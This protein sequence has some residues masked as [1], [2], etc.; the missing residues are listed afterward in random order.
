MNSMQ[1]LLHKPII[2]AGVFGDFGRVEY[3]KHKQ[4]Q[5]SRSRTASINVGYLSFTMWSREYLGLL[6][7]RRSTVPSFLFAWAFFNFLTKTLSKNRPKWFHKSLTNIPLPPASSYLKVSE[8]PYNWLVEQKSDIF[9]MVESFNL[10]HI[11]LLSSFTIA[12]LS[13]MDAF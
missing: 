10:C 4:R 6:A 2:S 13:R 7:L 11:S 12:R 5:S 1:S 3:K 9:F 8:F